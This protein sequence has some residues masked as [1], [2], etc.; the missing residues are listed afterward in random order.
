MNTS[1]ARAAHF[2]KLKAAE[3]KNLRQ[4]LGGYYS[5]LERQREKSGISGEKFS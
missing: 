4:Q 5:A 1:D 3:T 2:L